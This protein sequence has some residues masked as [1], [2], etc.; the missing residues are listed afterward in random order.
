MLKNWQSEP[1]EVCTSEIDLEILRSLRYAWYSPSQSELSD[2][3]WDRVFKQ[4]LSEHEKGRTPN[5]DILCNREIKFKSFYDY[6]LK[7]GADFATGIMQKLKLIME[8]KLYRS[9]DINKDQTYFTQISSKEFSKTI[10]PLSDI[11]KSG[12]VIAKET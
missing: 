4:F 7:I 1:G 3:Y 8:K 6:A 9:K 12:Q 11:Y 5:P 2:D 10:F